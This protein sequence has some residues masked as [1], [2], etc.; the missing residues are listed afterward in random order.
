MNYTGQLHVYSYNEVLDL[1]IDRSQK[2]LKQ[3][4]E[5][6]LQQLFYSSVKVLFESSDELQAATQLYVDVAILY[7]NQFQVHLLKKQ[8]LRSWKTF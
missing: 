5:Y 2:T 8:K 1:T 4:S 6:S 3:W 7:Y